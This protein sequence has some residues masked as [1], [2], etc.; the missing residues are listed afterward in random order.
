[1]ASPGMHVLASHAEHTEGA[2]D[3]NQ[4]RKHF[5]W[6]RKAELNWGL[7]LQIL[8]TSKDSD[9]KA[10]MLCVSRHPWEQWDAK[11]SLTVPSCASRKKEGTEEHLGKP[12]VTCVK[13]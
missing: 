12:C 7:G 1:M 5:R 2:I 8:F 11:T 4:H 13:V 10:G 3:T 9:G 6:A